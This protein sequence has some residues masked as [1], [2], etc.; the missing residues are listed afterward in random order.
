MARWAR[1]RA[2]EDDTS[3]SR[4]VGE[5]LREKMLAEKSY[6]MAMDEYLSQPPPRSEGSCSKI[7]KLIVSAAQV[8]DC[9]Y[10]LTEDLQDA[11]MFGNLQ[12]INPFHTAPETL[13]F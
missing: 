13:E 6:Q 8:T 2:A 11:Q 10:L 4:L 9:R 1:I 7:S 5:M 12:V 3:V